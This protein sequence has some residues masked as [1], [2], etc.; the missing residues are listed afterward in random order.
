MAAKAN[1]KNPAKKSILKVQE[2]LC[3][4]MESTAGHTA[5]GQKHQPTERETYRFSKSHQGEDQHKDLQAKMEKHKLKALCAAYQKNPEE[6]NAEPTE[7]H[8]DIDR[9]EENIFLDHSVCTKVSMP[10]AL[11]FS[12]S[13]TPLVVLAPKSFSPTSEPHKASVTVARPTMLSGDSSSDDSSCDDTE[14]KDHSDSDSSPLVV[15]TKCQLQDTTV[16]ETRPKIMKVLNGSRQQLK[17]SDFDE[18]T[19]DLLATATSIYHCLIVT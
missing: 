19:K 10:H 9:D 18:L 4:K 2:D 5:S 12:V 8:S 14:S 16:E 3:A 7:L 15:R 11:T 13:K 17:A 1:F 6:F